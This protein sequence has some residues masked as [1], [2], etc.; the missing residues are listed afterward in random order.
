[1]KARFKELIKEQDIDTSAHY[2]LSQELQFEYHK[3]TL[4]FSMALIGGMVTLKTALN[5]VTPINEGFGFALI[6]AIMSAL[7]SFEAQ[8]GVIKDLRQGTTPNRFKRTYRSV[9]A[10]ACLGISLSMAYDYFQSSIF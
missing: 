10:P 9:A 3:S 7:F 8:T 1:M 4:T 2:L 6:A 5:I